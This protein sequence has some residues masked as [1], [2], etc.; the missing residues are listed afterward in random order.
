MGDVRSLVRQSAPVDVSRPFDE[1]TLRDKTIVITGGANGLGTHFVRRWASAGAHVVIGD[2]DDRAGEQFVAE[3][4]S[5]YPQSTFVFQHCD[6]T[7][8]ESQVSLFETAVRASPQGRGIDIVVPNAGILVPSEAVKFG[9]PQ[10]VDGV[11]A[12]PNTATLDVNITGV[13]YTTHLAL[14][15]LPRNGD[16]GRDRCIL[17]I[18]SLSSLVPLP[19]QDQ[20]TMS[21]HAVVG[22]FRSLRGTAAS[23]H[24][25]RV[26]MIAPFYVGKTNMLKPQ[27]EALLLSGSAGPARIADVV[28]AATRL[29]ADEGIVGRALV[30]GPRLKGSTLAEVKDAM[31]VSDDE[32]E[33][34]GRAVWECYAGDYDQVDTFV[35]RYLMLLNAVAKVKGWVGM[36]SDLWAIWKRK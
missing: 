21:K 12:K 4:R 27:T 7:D 19:G 20:Y 8:W 15:H 5:T 16:G 23:A 28:D 24:G 26:N 17:L 9:R 32:G 25:V 6:V 34:E 29:L 10:L 3:L 14:Y 35:K 1:T 18:G 22:L 11:L 31:V 36:L 30:V 2:L 13:A 33:G